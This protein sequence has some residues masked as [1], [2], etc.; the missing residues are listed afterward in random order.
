MAIKAKHEVPNG[1][2]QI[3]ILPIGVAPSKPAALAGREPSIE[4]AVDDLVTR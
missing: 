4:D 2:R 3:C 1:R